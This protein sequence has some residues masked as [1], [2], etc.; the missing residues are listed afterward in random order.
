MT[1]NLFEMQLKEKLIKKFGNSCI[2]CYKNN[3][4]LRIEHIFGQG[5]LEFEYY[6]RCVMLTNLYMDYYDF[7]YSYYLNNFDS[8]SEFIGLACLKC[9]IYSPRYPKLEDIFTIIDDSLKDNNY[10]EFELFVDMHPHTKPIVN[11]LFRLMDSDLQR[12]R[13]CRQ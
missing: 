8:E 1:K 11:R 7:L 3:D 4:E 10:E 2:E 5:N 6:Q 12:E 9:K 13:R